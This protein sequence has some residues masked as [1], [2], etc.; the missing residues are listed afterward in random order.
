[1]LVIAMLLFVFCVDLCTQNCSNGL[2]ASIK[3]H[4]SRIS[5]TRND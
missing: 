4:F 2:H 3:L 5:T 1:M